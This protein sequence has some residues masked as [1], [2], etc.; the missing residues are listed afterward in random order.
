LIVDS[1]QWIVEQRN[2]AEGNTKLRRS[3][4]PCSGSG[5]HEKLSGTIQIN[6]I[7]ASFDFSFLPGGI[8]VYRKRSKPG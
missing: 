2:G 4:G 6:G 1:L 3:F 5:R 7:L 8:R